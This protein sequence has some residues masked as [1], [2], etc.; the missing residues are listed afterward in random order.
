MA[1]WV[2]SRNAQI[3]DNEHL[4][5]RRFKRP[6]LIGFIGQEPRPTLSYLDFLDD[7]DYDIS[8]DRL[9]K[10]GVDPKVK[11][12]LRPLAE[13][14]A[15]KRTPK[16]VFSGWASVQVKKFMNDAQK[17]RY[18]IA[19][20]PIR[21]TESENN[22]YHAIIS[23][24]TDREHLEVALTLHHWFAKYGVLHD[25]EPVP[26]RGTLRSILDWF[27]RFAPRAKKG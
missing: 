19:P 20:D 16:M 22:E 25:V 15:Q 12:V 14:N 10:N 11:E 27:Q 7:R 8:V 17:L 1:K 13:A 9:G 6:Q 21:E 18:S 4:G 24:P 2:P 26:A 3:G 23:C 5:R